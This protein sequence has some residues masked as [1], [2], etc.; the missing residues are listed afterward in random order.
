MPNVFKIAKS[1]RRKP[2]NKN[3]SWQS[4]VKQAGRSVRGVKKKSSKK[5]RVG[6]VRVSKTV[7][8]DLRS[9]KLRMPHGYATVKRA[10]LGSVSGLM[11]SAKAQIKEQ[12]GWLEASKFGAKTAKS[13]RA[14]GKRIAKLKAQYRKLC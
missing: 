10:R 11:S 9:K 1:L 4:L 14:Y 8:K 7:R 3:K 12:I 13:K 2:G 6:N 5:R